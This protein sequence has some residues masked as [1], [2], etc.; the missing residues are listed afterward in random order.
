M[1]Q[2]LVKHK[3]TFLF[4]YQTKGYR[5]SGNSLETHKR[6]GYVK[7]DKSRNSFVQWWNAKV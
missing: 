4:P 7:T 6:K 1:M 5:K 2:Y 3:T